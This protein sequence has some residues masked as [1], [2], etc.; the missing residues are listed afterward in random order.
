MKDCATE[1][2]YTREVLPPRTKRALVSS[3]NPRAKWTNARRSL[4]TPGFMYGSKWPT[5]IMALRRGTALVLGGLFLFTGCLPYSCQR[6]PSEALYPSDSLSRQVAQETPTDT[7]QKLWGTAGTEAH[8]LTH[9]RTVRFVGDSSL[10]VSDVERN[11]LF[12]VGADGGLRR[13][14]ADGDFRTPYLIGTQGDTLIVFNAETNRIDRVVNGRRQAGESVTF[15]RPAP[16]T[17]VYML[18]TDTTMYAKVVGQRTESF[19]ARL[20]DEGQSV[21]RA[22]LEGPHWRYAG[23]LR[24]WGDSLVSLS[25]FRP[26]VDLLPRSFRTGARPD[27]LALVGFDSPM[28]ERSYAFGQGDA[29]EAPLLTSA[30]APV[31]DTLFVLNLRP[32]WVQIDA[33]DRSGRLQRQLVERHE[34]GSPNFYPLDLDARRAEDGYVFAV[35]IRSPEP[36]LELFRWQSE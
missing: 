31:G 1:S 30:A 14:M 15:E 8:P 10:A 32:G 18:A 20:G 19:I 16:E 5:I 3:F 33:Y 2:C 36:R 11:S 12:W 22:P 29:T 35:A 23:F 13:E 27:S 9:P 26:V 6:Q 25:G 34:E 24:A 17:L 21:A 4:S 28:L 7:L